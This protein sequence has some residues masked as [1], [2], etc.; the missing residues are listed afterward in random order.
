MPE[1]FRFASTL[2]TVHENFKHIG[3]V[4]IVEHHQCISISSNSEL[5]YK[6]KN[7]I[8]NLPLDMQ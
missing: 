1:M 2:W 5:S 7:H 6:M 8:E 3:V 4:N